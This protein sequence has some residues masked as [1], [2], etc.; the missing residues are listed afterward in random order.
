[1]YQL[2]YQPLL[3]CAVRKLVLVHILNDV[4]FLDSATVNR[5]LGNVVEAE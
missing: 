5:L 4:Q 3:L 2:Q 1:M